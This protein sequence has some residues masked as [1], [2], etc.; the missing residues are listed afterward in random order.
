MTA[1]YKIDMEA[2]IYREW[3]ELEAAIRTALYGGPNRRK[4]ELPFDAFL[5]KEGQ[6]FRAWCNTQVGC[7]YTDEMFHEDWLRTAMF[8]AAAKYEST[9]AHRATSRKAGRQSALSKKESNS[10]RDQGIREQFRKMLESGKE[11]HTIAARLVRSTRLSKSTI[12]RILDFP[13]LP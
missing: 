12:Y 11:S 8:L 6:L 7:P 5:F 9:Q 2:A 10:E 13:K 3:S 4:L 1:S